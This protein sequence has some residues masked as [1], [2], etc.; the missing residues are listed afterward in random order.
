MC[1]LKNIY[2][3]STKDKN[4]S[5]K[6]IH[7]HQKG[8]EREKKTHYSPPAGRSLVIELK[9]MG[10]SLLHWQIQAS[11]RASWRE[12]PHDPWRCRPARPLAGPPRLPH[13]FLHL[14][15]LLVP[16]V[17]YALPLS[18]LPAINVQAST[19]RYSLPSSGVARGSSRRRR[20]RSA[21]PVEKEARL[22]RR[23]VPDWIE[24]TQG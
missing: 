13:C 11:T 24:L 7:R 10:A 3:T 21:R 12:P 5:H 18:E 14:D 8:L 6:E 1:N 2:I 16:I 20:R 9:A 22:I 17:L 23:G 15:D 4:D 19:S